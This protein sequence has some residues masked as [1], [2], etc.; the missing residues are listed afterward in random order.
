MQPRLESHHLQSHSSGKDQTPRESKRLEFSERSSWYTTV[1]KAL[2]KKR[3]ISSLGKIPI[4]L[5]FRVKSVSDTLF[6]FYSQ[7]LESAGIQDNELAFLHPDQRNYS[8]TIS[9]QN[10]ENHDSSEKPKN[11][12][13][14]RVRS[15][16]NRFNNIST[17]TPSK[18][19][20]EK[21]TFAESSELFGLGSTEIAR[22]LNTRI[23]ATNENRLPYHT[24]QGVINLP[25]E[26]YEQLVNDPIES[27]IN[28]RVLFATNADIISVIQ[29]ID[30]SFLPV[31]VRSRES[32]RT[33]AR[34]GVNML[35]NQLRQSSDEERREILE[36]IFN[37][38]ISNTR[39]SLA[40]EDFASNIQDSISALLITYARETELNL[41]TSEC[42]EYVWSYISSYISFDHTIDTIIESAIENY[43]VLENH[44]QL[45]QS[46]L[47]QTLD[48]YLK[49][50]SNNH[51]KIDI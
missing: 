11:Y 34:L 49:T 23:H 29:N 2:L 36:C 10:A 41:D 6:S 51:E 8:A 45:V 17:N 4:E 9:H 5:G 14:S 15:I 50:F 42:S 21:I 47:N 18:E 20:Q 33:I 7:T 32:K 1:K 46:E 12:A 16:I 3:S 13:I 39:V 31:K 26:D 38:N 35:W 19:I 22:E 25:V 24:T 48:S 27:I 43:I 37:P 30:Y 44:K 28:D 40:L